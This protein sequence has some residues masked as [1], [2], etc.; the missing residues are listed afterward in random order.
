MQQRAV[1]T[2]ARVLTAAAEVFARTGFLAA[3]MNDIVDQAGVTKGAVYFH[4]ASKE[5]LAV[6]VVEEQFRQ[7]PGVVAAIGAHSPDELTAIVAL[8]Y[9]VGARFRDDV[10]VTAGIRLSFERGLVNADMPTPFVGWVGQLQTMFG[11]AR[12]AGLLRAGVQPAPT[13]R[14]L[15]GSFF[16]VQHVSE[17][18]TG[19]Q[20][21][22]IRLDEF[23]K[24]FLVGIAAE[25]DWAAMQRDVRKVRAA[26]RRE[27]VREELQAAGG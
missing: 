2:R 27:L 5:A 18:L 17:I 16:G 14:A 4:F 15:V 9:E 26:L 25:P 1:L 21:L 23:W 8:T 6:A 10:L 3:S 12:R 22:E 13:A 20:D 19:R 24:I 11:R 7:W